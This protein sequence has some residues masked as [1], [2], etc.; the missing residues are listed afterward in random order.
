MDS[1][2]ER[3][4]MSPDGMLTN[5]DIEDLC[6]ELGEDSLQHPLTEL[7]ARYLKRQT[8]HTGDGY[9]MLPVNERD[10]TSEGGHALYS[11]PK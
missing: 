10:A 7:R 11:E 5:D 2:I 6:H 8:A 9:A 3:C 1:Y 4:K